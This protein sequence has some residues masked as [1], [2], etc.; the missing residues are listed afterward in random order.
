MADGHKTTTQRV[1]DIAANPYLTVIARTAMVFVTFIAAPVIYW[2]ISTMIDVNNTMSTIVLIQTT[3]QE[4]IQQ[5]V[6]TQ[7]T[8]INTQA[9]E[10]QTRAVTDAQLNAQIDA[11]RDNLART[12]RQLEAQDARINDLQ[13]R[14]YDSRRPAQ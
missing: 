6:S 5:L 9:N 3:Q 4:Q 13:R 7:S 2:V 8:V 12:E 10:G 14:I 1:G 11:V